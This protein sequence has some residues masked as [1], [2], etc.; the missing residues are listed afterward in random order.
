MSLNDIMNRMGADKGSNGHGY[1]IRYEQ[2]FGPAR[3]RNGTLVEIGICN[4]YSI[5]AWREWAPNMRVIGLDTDK[6]FVDE[7]KA[8]GAEAYHGDGTTSAMWDL[9]R[10]MGIDPDVVVDDGSHFANDQ[11]AAFEA[12]FPRLKSGGIYAIE[13]LHTSYW[14]TEPYKSRGGSVMPF[15]LGLIDRLN[16]FGKVNQNGHALVSDIAAIHFYTSIVFVEKR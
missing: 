2:H 13:D 8:E 10:A 5:R 4:G 14:P 16:N 6:R 12:I 1:A 15:L 11:R 3:E 9:L 7:A